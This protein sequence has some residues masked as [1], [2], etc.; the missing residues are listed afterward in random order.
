M[1][2]PDR[3]ERRALLLTVPIGAVLPA[4]AY[5]PFGARCQSLAQGPDRARRE[6]P[7]IS[8]P[9]E[10]KAALVTGGN[11]GIGKATAIA[12]AEAGA[13]VVIA[14]RRTAEG[15]RAVEEIRV[16]G[17]EALFVE[18]DVARARDV[19]ALVQRTAATYGRLDCAFNNAGV[20]G[21]GLLHEFT[22]ADWDRIIDINL[23]GVWLCMKYQIAQMLR[24]SGGAIVNDSSAAGL[25]G[26]TR[27]PVYSASKHG[28]IGL[29]RSA[30]LQYVTQGI[31]VNAVCPG[32]I[33][34]ARMERVFATGPGIKEWFE[35]QQP[36]GHGGRPEE[37]AQAVVW[38]CSDAASFVTGVAFPIDGGSLAG[39]W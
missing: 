17:G 8:R 5:H 10:G 6:E 25:V 12:F 33:M 24:Q 15:E 9:F 38:L 26:L 11:D 21:G 23:K 34:T 13:K 30:A 32:L 4:V 36:T 3:H 18:T 22:E 39:F 16:K 29:S 35:S 27:S 2:A 14:A 20:A 1:V 37:V 19:E 28:V 31:R 7:S